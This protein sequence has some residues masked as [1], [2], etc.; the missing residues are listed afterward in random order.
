MKRFYG[1]TGREIER[2]EGLVKLSVESGPGYVVQSFDEKWLIP[3]KD[4]KP[5]PPLQVISRLS[6]VR[7]RYIIGLAHNEKPHLYKLECPQ[8][9]E[10]EGYE[11]Q[12]WATY[13]L[14]CLT[15]F[16]NKDIHWYPVQ[17]CEAL[18]NIGSRV[19]S[20]SD[21]IQEEEIKFLAKLEYYFERAFSLYKCH[22]L[23]VRGARHNPFKGH[24]TLL[25]LRGSSTQEDELS[26]KYYDGLSTPW[27]ENKNVAELL[28]RFTTR[29][30][31]HS[32]AKV[33]EVHNTA[34]QKGDQCGLWC[35]HYAEEEVRNYLGQ[36][37]GSQGFPD[38]QRL[39]GSANN[40]NVQ[41]ALFQR[42]KKV[43]MQLEVER[44][45]WVN[46]LDIIDKKDLAIFKS[47]RA[48]QDAA[49]ERAQGINAIERKLRQAALL[50]LRGNEGTPLIYVEA[51]VKK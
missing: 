10:L 35:M 5:A 23:L 41:A 43:L 38:R 27:P 37:Y 29:G 47:V 19:D 16:E 2:S 24:W 22:L 32:E 4:L 8:K 45:K 39:V 18:F 12:V 51:E 1:C 26:I 7:K 15:E 6:S 36:G 30:S 48:K 3:T 21:P 49:D 31:T 33:P 14:T 40:K 28:L 42:L 34:K 13:M 20:T 11:I 44:L 25:S 9:T 17:L 46:E 50:S